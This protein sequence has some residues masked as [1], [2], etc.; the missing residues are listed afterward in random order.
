MG[1]VIPAGYGLLSFHTLTD[2][3]PEEM[4]W[5]VGV[6][7]GG[8]TD[9]S[10][11]PFDAHTAWVD[12]LQSETSS[13]V[14]LARIVLKVGPS[15]TGPTYE[16]VT[17]AS[18]T[19]GGSL[20]PPNCAVLCKKLTTAGGRKG[21]GRCYLPGISSISGT[22]DSAGNFAS[23]SA[24]VISSAMNQ[25]LLDISAG[26]TSGGAELVLLHSDSTAPNLITEFFCEP[27]LATQRRRLRP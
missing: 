11:V 21:R 27:K 23:G 19:N 2:G 6:N 4:V 9:E 12:N 8:T 7:L 1:V 24:G 10:K 5:T 25:L 22:L 16:D 14:D 18:G 20:P 13:V 15:S 17:A 3:D 26:S